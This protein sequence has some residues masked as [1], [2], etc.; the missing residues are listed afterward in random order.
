MPGPYGLNLKEDPKCEASP[1]FR[2]GLAGS[3]PVKIDSN[4]ATTKL[5]I[6]ELTKQIEAQEQNIEAMNMDEELGQEEIMPAVKEEPAE[7]GINRTEE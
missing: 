6:Q 5:H 2:A 3:M 4:L 1:P 7:T